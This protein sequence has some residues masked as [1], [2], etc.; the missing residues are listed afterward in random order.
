M[1]N[2]NHV[3][4]SS[5]GEGFKRAFEDVDATRYV[6]NAQNSSNDNSV[7]ESPVGN[8]LSRVPEYWYFTVFPMQAIEN[9]LTLVESNLLGLIGSFSGSMKWCFVSQ[10]IMG[11]LLGRGDGAIAE[12]LHGLHR[13]NLIEKSAAKFKGRTD[14]WRLTVDARKRR[15]HLKALAEKRSTRSFRAEEGP[16]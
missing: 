15:T 6:Q 10:N 7:I 16:K 1:M 13:K 4:S 9:N 5:S 2:G 11:L 12:A 8:E 14:Q 3:S